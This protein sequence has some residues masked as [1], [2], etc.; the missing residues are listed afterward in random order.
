M[1]WDS[2]GGASRGPTPILPA[3]ARGSFSTRVA[4]QYS[5]TM[6]TPLPAS[7]SPGG[8]T[9][10]T[11]PGS[12]LIAARSRCRAASGCDATPKSRGGRGRTSPCV[13]RPLPSTGTAYIMI[14]LESE[15][16][17]PALIWVR[18]AL[19]FFG[20]Q[21]SMDV[22]DLLTNELPVI[23]KLFSIYKR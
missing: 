23:A 16:P 3:S 8:G 21:C 18:R 10:D 13:G 19:D 22:M 11:C 6:W 9:T 5:T 4:H 1:S 15:Y 17:G 14:Q 7:T 2:G 20:S 12:P